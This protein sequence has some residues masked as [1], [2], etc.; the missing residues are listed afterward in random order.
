MEN[1]FRYINVT[2]STNHDALAWASR[3][4]THGCS[5][6]AKHQTGGKGRLDRSWFSHPGSNLYCSIIV[7]PKLDPADYPKLALVAGLAVAE[8]IERYCSLSVGLKW[9]NDIFL[10]GKKC[11]GILCES[12]L[13]TGKGAS[14]FAIIGIGLNINMTKA[15]LTDEIKDKATSLQ[16]EGCSDFT[17]KMLFPRLH[18]SVL[19]L[20]YEF[21]KRGFKGI[22]DR[23]RK[24][25][26]LV[27][28]H[29][30]W[31]TSDG[32]I[33]FGICLGPDDEGM[34]YIRDETGQEHQVV[35]GDVNMAG[36][37]TAPP[38]K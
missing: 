23:W 14:R 8:S 20:V 28:K 29:T 12:S 19:K 10:S 15:D 25:D 7:K 36:A 35:S 32:R 31:V 22:L 11:G 16:I 3:G 27:G 21:E 13:G 26:V 37:E 24:R 30:S 1:K 18:D 2:G 34:L 38:E 6:I 33:V 4:A 5:V 17:P 9:P